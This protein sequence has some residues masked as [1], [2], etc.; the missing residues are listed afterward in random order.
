MSYAALHACP[1]CASVSHTALG[2]K[3]LQKDVRVGCSV[4]SGHSEHVKFE[5]RK[6]G[7]AGLGPPL[8]DPGL[9]CGSA[10]RRCAAP[11][12]ETRKGLPLR[13]GG[14][15]RPPLAPTRASDVRVCS[16][17][18]A[19]LT[20]AVPLPS[21]GSASRL[22]QSSC[23]HLARSW[24]PPTANCWG[25]SALCWRGAAQRRLWGPAIP[26]RGVGVTLQPGA[27]SASWLPHPARPSALVSAGRGLADHSSSVTVVLKHLA[28]TQPSLGSSRLVL[29]RHVSAPNV[30]SPK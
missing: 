27:S 18:S 10:D 28:A 30:K 8:L 9:C 4:W 1:V 22:P 15:S 14:A 29:R 11:F 5:A 12:C 19:F 17:L 26:S 25:H 16:V 3:R 2:A 21:S 13:V 20:P 7:S 24:A 23:P 6:A